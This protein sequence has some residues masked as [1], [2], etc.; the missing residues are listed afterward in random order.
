MFND[1]IYK[2]WNILPVINVDGVERPNFLPINTWLMPVICILDFL[3]NFSEVIIILF[4]FIYSVEKWDI[5]Q[6][7]ALKDI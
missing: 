7:N 1:I 6:I 5:L 2:K 4:H 3:K